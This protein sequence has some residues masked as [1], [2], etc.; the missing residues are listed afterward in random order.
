MGTSITVGVTGGLGSGKS[1][2]CNVFKILGVP[3][4]EADKVGKELLNKNEKVKSEVIHLFGEEIYNSDG[5]VNR[6]KLAGIIFNDEIQLQKINKIVHPEVKIEFEEWLKNQHSSYII[7]EAAI[8]FESGFY[9]LMD[10]KILVTAPEEQRIKWVMKR[11]NLNENQIRERM[12][13][14]WPEEKKQKLA[15]VVLHNDNRNLL[16]P[17]IIKMDKKLKRNGKIW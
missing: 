15:D 8:L 16:I 11:D 10:F 1:T 14:Q 7:H 3:V 6:K 5:T 17:L 13:R 2:V 4:F 12:K 9:K